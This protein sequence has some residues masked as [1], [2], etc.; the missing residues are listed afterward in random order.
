MPVRSEIGQV[1]KWKLYPLIHL[2]AMA[3]KR[4]RK[5]IIRITLKTGSLP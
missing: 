2:A 5:K 4:G 1:R 3:V